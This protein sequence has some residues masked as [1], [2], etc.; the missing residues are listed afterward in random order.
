MHEMSKK[1][2][3]SSLN[4]Q[5]DVQHATTSDAHVRPDVLTLT[6]DERAA[7]LRGEPDTLPE[8]LCRHCKVMVRPTGKGLCPRCAK[9]VRLNFVARR[10]PINVARV[11]QLNAQLVAEYRPQTMVARTTCRHLAGTWERLE[12]NKPGS[13]EWQRL[14]AVSQAQSQSLRDMCA[15]TRQG[16][17]TL[18]LS[19]RSF[20]DLA[21]LAASIAEHFFALAIAERQGREEVAAAAEELRTQQANAAVEE[22]VEAVSK[23]E[24]PKPL[25]AWF[26]A[27]LE[28]QS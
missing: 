11:D 7:H 3:A 24:T 18:D 23:G 12:H 19:H 5:R 13:P 15:E 8:V 10:H 16:N 20:A 26:S 1:N 14:T 25:P 6:D 9:F 4:L 27:W 17:A 22:Q 28:K 21:E 2:D